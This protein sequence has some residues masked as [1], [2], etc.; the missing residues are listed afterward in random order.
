M[1]TFNTKK[2]VESLLTGTATPDR[3]SNILSTSGSMENSLPLTAAADDGRFSS[4]S[5]VHLSVDGTR[6]KL[7]FTRLV[8]C[9]LILLNSEVDESDVDFLTL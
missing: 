9:R 7:D 2:K 1:L 3:N 6:G 8:C 4:C 5:N